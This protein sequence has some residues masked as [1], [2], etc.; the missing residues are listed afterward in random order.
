MTAKTLKIRQRRPAYSREESC[1]ERLNL[2][3][4]LY[5]R[6]GFLHPDSAFAVIGD[7]ESDA[8]RSAKSCRA[9]CNGMMEKLPRELRDNVYRYLIKETVSIRELVEQNTGKSLPGKRLKDVAID[10]PCANQHVFDESALGQEIRDELIE[11]IY[12]KAHFRLKVDDSI[13]Q[14]L[15]H[16]L[17]KS[18]IDSRYLI[19]TIQVEIYDLVMPWGFRLRKTKRERGMRSAM[20]SKADLPDTIH[21]SILDAQEWYEVSQKALT[22]EYRRE[23]TQN[24]W[25]GQR[26]RNERKADLYLRRLTLLLRELF[27]FRTG[28]RLIFKIT[29]V[30]P[31]R[32]EE[33]VYA[34]ASKSIFR[35]ILCL[36]QASFRVVLYVNELP[37][38][39][40]TIKAWDAVEFADWMK[41][42]RKRR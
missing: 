41:R 31:S 29:N 9:L 11:A 1:L 12:R 8:E 25:A 14:F 26:E 37:L 22:F 28:T 7:V 23:A 4:R 13:P 2:A 17:W 34:E 20:L 5:Q 19:S 21:E 18:G 15:N 36:H 10:G 38:D 35:S 30:E 32:Q 40:N 33:H 39:W 24:Y 42:T 6:D 27:L 16:D 3:Y